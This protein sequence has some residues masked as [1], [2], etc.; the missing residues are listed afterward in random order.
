[1]KIIF[2]LLAGLV[3]SEGCITLDSYNNY[4][5]FKMNISLTDK[6]LLKNVEKGIKNLGFSSIFYVKEIDSSHFGKKP[7]WNLNVQ[8]KEG[9]KRLLNLLFP[10]LRHD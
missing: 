9:M 1:M 3:N 10:F 6:K 2:N 7:V 4:L 8:R 5:R